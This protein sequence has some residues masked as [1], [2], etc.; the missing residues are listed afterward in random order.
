MSEL[1]YD[2]LTEE[3]K[4]YYDRIFIANEKLLWKENTQ[5]E[6]DYWNYINTTVDYF[7][8]VKN[9]SYL[10]DNSFF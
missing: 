10:D 6:E 5:T 1:W 8:L 4:E 3:D 2:N 9:S 7:N